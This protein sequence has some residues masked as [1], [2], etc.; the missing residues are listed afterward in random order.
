MLFLVIGLYLGSLS[1]SMSETAAEIY[2]KLIKTLLIFVMAWFVINVLDQSIAQYLEPLAKKSKSELDDNLVPL[3]RKLIK[4]TLVI[5]AVIMIL[6]DLGFD[7]AS[8]LAGLGIGGLAFALAAK[9]LIA[10]IFGGIAIVMDKSFKIGDKIKVLGVDG[11]VEQIGLRTTVLRSDSGT[12]LILP[13][14]KI[15]DNVIE[16]LSKDKG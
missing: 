2:I 3:L 16:N 7:V 15:A 8:I 12:K 6:S 1:L 9:D 4:T 10:N 13:N 14:S 11:K 5:I